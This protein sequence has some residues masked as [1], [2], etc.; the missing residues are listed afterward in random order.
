M[1]WPVS[2]CE[3]C[4]VVSLTTTIRREIWYFLVSMNSLMRL[5]VFFEV[6]QKLYF[7]W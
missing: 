2:L 4:M 5:C 6:Y 7:V 3:E 1:Y